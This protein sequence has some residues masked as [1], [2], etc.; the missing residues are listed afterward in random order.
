MQDTER[1]T[2]Q[3]KKRIKWWTSTHFGSYLCE[4]VHNVKINLQLSLETNFVPIKTCVR[5]YY[6]YG[7]ITWYSNIRALN[8]S[9]NYTEEEI[10]QLRYFVTP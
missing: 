5:A 2:T 7:V 8:F 6:F 3:E 4:Q 1:N 10:S 9:L